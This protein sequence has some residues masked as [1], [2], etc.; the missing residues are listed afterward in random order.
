[1]VSFESEN[2]ILFSADAFGKFGALD[3]NDDWTE[4]ARR[5]YIGIVGKYGVQVQAL[6]KKLAKFD[7]KAI[8]PLHGPVLKD[9][10]AKYLHLYDLWSSYQP[11]EDGVLIAYSSVY[12][13]T[14]NAVKLLKQ[15]LTECGVKNV[16]VCDL[17]RDDRS[18]AVANAFR[19]NK[20][21]LAT[22]TYNAG[23]F[24]AMSE[25]IDNLTER[26]FKNRTVAF[27]E[28]GTWA[29]MAAKLM[30]AKFEK[31]VGLTYCENVVKIRSNLN[32]ESEGQIYALA[33]ELSKK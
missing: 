11:E 18:Q 17:V 21:V 26:N 23:I 3:T 31:S 6:F 10:L 29:P 8:A 22:T 7:I 24:P 9:N 13:H 1:M 15:K 2:Q 28:N 30:Q 4:E 27:I 14:A 16:T 12:G 25:F 32:A 19:Y 33:D 5:Y 20:I